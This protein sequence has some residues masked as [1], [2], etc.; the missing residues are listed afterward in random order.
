MSSRSTDF[1]T[2]AMDEAQRAAAMHGR[3]SSSWH[4]D[5]R[6]DPEELEREIDETRA[7]VQA[8]LY[9]L[10][11]KLSPEQLFDRTVG[12]MRDNGG[13]FVHN[14]SESVKHNPMPV[15]LTS[16]GLAWMMMADGRR[17][18]GNGHASER[19][20]ERWQHAKERLTGAKDRMGEAGR[21]LRDG[22]AAA[23]D[24]LERSRAAMARA[25]HAVGERSGRAASAARDELAQVRSTFNDLLHDQPLV[26]GAIGLAAGAIMG[27]ALPA[28]EQENRTLGR[29]RDRALDRAKEA[30]RRGYREVREQASS[31]AEDGKERLDE[32][33]RDGSE[34]RA[35]SGPERWPEDEQSLRPSAESEWERDAGSERMSQYQASSPENDRR[36]SELGARPRSDDEQPPI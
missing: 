33:L 30:G 24:T 11:R 34:Q 35:E 31:L 29:T 28:T 25:S 8:T 7:D 22:G 16:I 5:S 26:L 14:L 19:S 4:D 36:G 20:H 23:R 17:G 27:A 2:Q 15:L 32:S 6:K 10:E 21:S 12:R 18:N 1:D 9:A 3:R 13:E